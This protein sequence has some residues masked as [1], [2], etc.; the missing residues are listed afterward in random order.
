MRNITF[1]QYLKML[2][3]LT[4]V[5]FILALFVSHIAS[6]IIQDV[7]PVNSITQTR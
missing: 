2:M 6:T 4:G 5:A 3:F 7:Q 1:W